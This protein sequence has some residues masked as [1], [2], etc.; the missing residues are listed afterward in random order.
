MDRCQSE[1]EDSTMETPVPACILAATLLAF[2][3][4]PC[5]LEGA[6]DFG[7]FLPMLPVRTES[8]TPRLLFKTPNETPIVPIWLSVEDKENLFSAKKKSC[9]TYQN[10]T[11]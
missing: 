2:K 9:E 3:D 11:F 1:G 8:D 4:C 10:I 6:Y 5:L 7:T